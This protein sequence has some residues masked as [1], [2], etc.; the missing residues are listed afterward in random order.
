MASEDPELPHLDKQ[1]MNAKG[2]GSYLSQN[3]GEAGVGAH[4]QDLS[5][6]KPQSGPARAH[7]NVPQE[8]RDEGSSNL[9][10]EAAQRKHRSAPQNTDQCHQQQ[11]LT[12]VSTSSDQRKLQQ[13]GQFRS[14]DQKLRPP[15]QGGGGLQ[16]PVRVTH[17]QDKSLQQQQLSPVHNP[18]PGIDGWQGRASTGEVPHHHQR[19]GGNSH[20]ANTHPVQSQQQFEQRQQLPPGGGPNIP[21]SE[22]EGPNQRQA[23]QGAGDQGLTRPP[24]EAQHQGQPRTGGIPQ[25]AQPQYGPEPSY[26]PNTFP[27]WQQQQQQHGGLHPAHGAG[28]H[29]QVPSSVN[30]PPGQEYHE[31]TVRYQ[32][33]QQQFNQQ[34]GQPNA[35]LGARAGGQAQPQQLPSPVGHPQ[36]NDQQ[37]HPRTEEAAQHLQHGPQRY[38]HTYLQAQQFQERQQQSQGLGRQNFPD[39]QAHAGQQYP[40]PYSPQVEGQGYPQQPQRAGGVPPRAGGMLPRAGGTNPNPV[41]RDKGTTMPPLQ[42]TQGGGEHA[43]NQQGSRDLT[44]V[45]V[46][47]GEH[48]TGVDHCHPRPD[49]SHNDMTTNRQSNVHSIDTQT[50]VNFEEKP[51]SANFSSQTSRPTSDAVSTQTSFEKNDPG[52]DPP[53]GE[54]RGK[55]E[56]EASTENILIENIDDEVKQMA[57]EVREEVGEDRK[58]LHTMQQ[59]PFDPNLVCP[60]CT[61]KFRI[62]EIQK[63][64][65]HVDACEGTSD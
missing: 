35:M 12:G 58:R 11:Q 53:K 65:A 55:L 60:M 46:F 10:H 20:H 47:D 62:G 57:Q 48:Q 18:P 51:H 42:T 49:C 37:G 23:T 41:P 30:R 4:S 52:N 36:G 5:N 15:M 45:N 34:Y 54:K 33:S 29:P 6:Q 2:T 40:Q 16:G 1:F 7:E 44:Y 39:N 27:Q 3:P 61:R 13:Q 26:R 38:H 17:P 25:P 21:A 9:D 56:K 31:G 32:Q 19:S 24:H 14:T 22:G 43:M 50:S 63:F 59:K 64:R 28:G 8:I